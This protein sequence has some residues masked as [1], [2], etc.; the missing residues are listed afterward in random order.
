MDPSLFQ[1]AQGMGPYFSF[2]V[3]KWN[4]TF[5]SN[6]EEM[7]PSGAFPMN[8]Y[9]ESA[10]MPFQFLLSGSVSIFLNGNGPALHYL[11]SKDQFLFFRN[12]EGSIPLL[13]LG[14]I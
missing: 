10:H 8:K 5:L 3:T 14:K 11:I 6:V 13:P 7:D 12:M 9:W 4:G 2:F 1:A